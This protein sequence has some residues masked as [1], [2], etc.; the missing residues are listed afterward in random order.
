MTV[1]DLISMCGGVQ[2]AAEALDMHRQTVYMW[3]YYNK[4]PQSRL[5]QLSAAFPDVLPLEKIDMIWSKLNE[6]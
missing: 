4:M 1:K 2:K 3:Q 6:Q 5:Y